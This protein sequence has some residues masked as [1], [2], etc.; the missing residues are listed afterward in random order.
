MAQIIPIEQTD[1]EYKMSRRRVITR[2]GVMW[3]GQTC[4]LRCHFCYFLDRIHNKEHP[5]HPFMSLD[6]AKRICS[7]LVDYYG[8]N[9][10]DIQ[11]GEPT[12]YPYI[13]DLVRHCREIG[14]LPTLITNAIP[15]S[16]ARNCDQL[17]QAGIRDLLISIQ[18][19][20]STYDQIVGVD[21]AFPRQMRGLDNVVQASIPIRFNCV[22]SKPALP[23]LERIAHLAV[24]YNARVVNFLAFNPFE[25]QQLEGKRSVFNVPRYSEVSQ[26]LDPAMDIL[27][28][29]GIECN[30]R[31]FPI[32]MVA[33]RHRKSMYNF[34]QLSYDIHEWDYG[35]WSWTGMQPQRMRGGDLSPVVDLASVTYDPATYP[36]PL[37]FAANSVRAVVHRYPRL[38][39]KAEKIHRTVS[40]VVSFASHDE[41]QM[42]EPDILYRANGR[43]RASA[44]CRY[45]FA[46]ACEMCS[47]REICDGF[48]GDYATMLGVDEVQPIDGALRIRDPRYFIEDQEKVVEWEDFNWAL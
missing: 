30:V 38:R 41:A 24:E 47:A 22:L 27:D 6:K 12:I 20:D 7:T 2:R 14:L 40:R 26:H 3:L 39:P 36:G 11:G 29:A 44:H 42:S 17:K 28:D 25:D 48:H 15:L 8:N 23:Q 21:R 32:C 18:G 37:K 34:Q 1:T 31:Y 19:L 10:I 45:V 46:K 5:E 16:N 35:S 33:P 4:N 13:F 9:A 43:M